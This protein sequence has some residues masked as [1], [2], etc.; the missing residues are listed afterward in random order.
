[1]NVRVTAAAAKKAFWSKNVAD[2]EH[3]NV[4]KNLKDAKLDVFFLI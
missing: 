1:M 3:V 2:A 4:K